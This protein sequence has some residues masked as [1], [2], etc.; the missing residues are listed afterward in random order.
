MADERPSEPGSASRGFSTRAIRAAAR[1]PRV[2]QAAN[3]VPIYQAVTFSAEDS[4][5]LGAVVQGRREGYA[6]S[7]LRH[8]TGVA[9]A[10]AIA[11]LEGAEAALAFDSGM[12]AIHG[13][14]TASLAAGDH[15]VA[16]RAVYGSTRALLDRVLTRFGVRTTFV[17]ATDPDTVEAAISPRTRVLYLETISNPTLAMADLADL[18]RR[19][20]RHDLTVIVDNT[21]ASPYLCRP[22]ELGADLVVESCTKWIGG[23]SDVLAGAVAGPRALIDGLTAGQVDQGGTVAPFSA[24]LVLRGLET[25]A[26]RMDRHSATALALATFLEAAPQPRA[27]YYPGLAS[28]PQA[29]VARRELRAGGGMLALDLGTREAAA[30]FIDALTLPQRTASLGSVFTMAVHPPSTTHRQLNPQQLAEAGIAEGLVRISVGLEDA[31]DL[32]LDLAAG[33]AAAAR[34]GVP[35]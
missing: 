13:A 8:P 35:V 23:H 15:V 29:E 21:F 9:L 7:R 22:L 4:E 17:D 10:A 16:T 26:V 34:V 5:E 14:L 28:H 2:A 12:G 30:A 6:Y 33:L 1:V 20:H 24:F 25:L 27:V 32:R 18:A 3:A 11:E 19:G 31:D